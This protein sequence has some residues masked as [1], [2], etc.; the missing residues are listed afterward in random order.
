MQYISDVPTCDGT[1]ASAA[2][3]VLL[4]GAQA[5]ASRCRTAVRLHQRPAVRRGRRRH[6]ETGKE[7][8]RYR[9][10]GENNSSKTGQ[11]LEKVAKARDVI[12]PHGE[13]AKAYA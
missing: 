7:I 10:D 1:A 12:H 2:P 5:R 3:G 13:E 8:T 4:A 11:P 6:R 9:S